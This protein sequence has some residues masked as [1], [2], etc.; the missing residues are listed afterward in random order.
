MKRATQA[1]CELAYG[2]NVV[3]AR[4]FH[5][6]SIYLTAC[7][8]SGATCSLR[9][10]RAKKKKKAPPL[11]HQCVHLIARHTHNQRGPKTESNPINLTYCEL[12]WNFSSQP[13]KC[14]LRIIHVPCAVPRALQNRQMII[15][16]ARVCTAHGNMWLSEFV[17]PSPSARMCSNCKTKCFNLLQQRKCARVQCMLRQ[18]RRQTTPW[19]K[20]HTTNWHFGGSAES[21]MLLFN[22]FIF[23]N[24]QILI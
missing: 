21:E 7:V 5:N 6:C 12:I 16:G 4:R 19:E 15:S 22:N 24:N 10:T 3:P 17:A 14:A 8:C 18:R 2:T 20:R 23:N 11:E 13:P 1:N 9:G